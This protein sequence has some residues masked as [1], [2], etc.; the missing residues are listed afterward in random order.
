MRRG[1]CRLC[2]REA[3]LKRSHLI[4]RAIYRLCRD[5]NDEDP[6]TMTPEVVAKTSRQI[7]DYLLCTTCEDLFSKRGERYVSNLVWRRKDGFPFLNKLQLALPIRHTETHSVLSGE[8]V[9]I[10]TDKLAYY[11]LS[12]VWRSGVHEWTTIQNQTSSVALPAD[13]EESIRRFLLGETAL[14]EH[15]GVVVT[16]CSD[17][18][19]QVLV[20]LPTL[21]QGLSDVLIYRLLVR[22]V[23]FG[24]LI[25]TK[26]GIPFS[27]VCCLNSPEKRVFVGNRAEIRLNE[28]RHFF[29]ESRIARNVRL[30]S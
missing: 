30:A 14:P 5:D 11:A 17:L 28:V 10:D 6:I 20:L 18:A 19:S 21:F 9:G 26:P 16:V 22:G 13:Q 15:V 12:V 23:D 24:V 1:I 25:K 29:E 2:Q 7:R 3:E 4:G 8:Q 27:E